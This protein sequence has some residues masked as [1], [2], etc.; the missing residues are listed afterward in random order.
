MNGSPE[1]PMSEDVLAANHIISIEKKKSKEI[2]LSNGRTSLVDEDDYEKVCKYSWSCHKNGK[3]YF[4]AERQITINKRKH[5]IKMH[6]IIL[7]LVEGDGKIVDHINRNTLD[8][9]K[10]NLRV[11]TRSINRM[12]CKKNKNNSSGFRGVYWD[13]SHHT[14]QAQIRVNK[15]IKNCG[16]FS[17]K[18]SAALAYDKA[19]I[20]YR[21]KDAILNFP[22]Y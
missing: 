2:L 12:N 22:N 11:V 5:T 7:G 20:K 16:C 19:A 4:Y 13:V 1:S 18:I 3:G 9:R 6:R 10:C 14:W 21:G 17:D 8:N 15:K